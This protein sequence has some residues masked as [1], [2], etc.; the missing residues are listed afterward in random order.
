MFS[1]FP[2]DE[3]KNYAKNLIF[4]YN[5]GNRG[6]ADGSKQ[7]QY[8]GILAQICMCDMLNKKR[9][10]GNEGFDGG[11]DFLINNLS[12]D[13]KTMHR[14]VDV[15]NHYVHNF[16]GYQLNY[17]CQ[18]YIF[19]SYNIKQNKLTICGVISKQSF[20]DKAKFYPAGT[21]RTRD[22]GTTFPTKAPLYEIMQSEL[23]QIYSKQ[24][25][26]RKVRL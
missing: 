8:Y 10:I 17:P 21:L 7:E 6:K 18:F 15:Q 9:P 5:I 13:L 1:I 25:M 19:A 11:V 12:V 2:N 22:D 24:D 4:N 14:T 23:T 20:L 3:Q 26:I 16:I